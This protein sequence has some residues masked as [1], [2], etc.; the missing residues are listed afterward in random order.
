[1][2]Q[3]VQIMLYLSEWRVCCVLGQHRSTRRRVFESR[4]DEVRLT[5]DMI[6]LARQHGR[7]GYRR[8]AGDNMAVFPFLDEW[9]QPGRRHSARDDLS[10]INDER[11]ALERLQS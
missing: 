5:A 7:D 9:N 6:A 11:A 4:E 3:T 10:P 1:M 2:T 8:E